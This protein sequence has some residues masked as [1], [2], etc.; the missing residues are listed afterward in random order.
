MNQI[1]CCH[2]CKP[3]ERCLY[4]HSFC[5]EYIAEKQK[6]DD[7]NEMVNSKKK[8]RTDINSVLAAHGT[9]RCSRATTRSKVN[10]GR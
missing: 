2:F 8:A 7:Q 6:Q 5:K 10:G 9:H 3:P 4:C 1:Q